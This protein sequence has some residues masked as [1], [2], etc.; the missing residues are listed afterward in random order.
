MCLILI[1]EGQFLCFYFRSDLIGCDISDMQAV[2]IRES[3]EIAPLLE[4]FFAHFSLLRV[5]FSASCLTAVA[6]NAPT[7]LMRAL[8]STVSAI[9]SFAKRVLR[10]NDSGSG[11]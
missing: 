5:L 7:C 1:G 10:A 3:N 9:Q 8:E 11:H 2:L 6:C 4:V